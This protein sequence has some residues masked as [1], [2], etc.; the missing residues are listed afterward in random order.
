MESHII[1]TIADD[2]VFNKQCLALEKAIPGLQKG[3]FLH[4]VDDSKIQKY[5]LDGT[6]LRVIKDTVVGIVAIESIFPLD[7]YFR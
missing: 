7:V 3:D 2:A 6:E 4:D 5:S 1:Y